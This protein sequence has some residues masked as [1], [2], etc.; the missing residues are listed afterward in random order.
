MKTSP[1]NIKISENVTPYH[2]NVARRVPIP[3]LPKVESELRRMERDGVIKK[4]TEPTPW[5][6]T[7]FAAPKK[8][9]KVRIC[10]D[11]KQL[12]KVVQRERYIIPAIPQV[13]AK[14]AGSV[15]FSKLDAS[16]GYWQ[17]A[18]KSRR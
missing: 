4:I 9:D 5:C 3:F 6:T 7:M 1:V 17:L 12:K 8:P 18:L 15:C 13:L 16:G 14:L 11:L 10:I 2:V